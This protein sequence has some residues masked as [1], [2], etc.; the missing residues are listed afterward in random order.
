MS[1]EINEDSNRAASTQMKPNQS[2]GW[3]AIPW[4]RALSHP[5]NPPVT[6][7]EKGHG[8]ASNPILLGCF[9]LAV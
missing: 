9:A 4:A 2:L 5:Y 1:V 3:I 8:R 7:D 6:I